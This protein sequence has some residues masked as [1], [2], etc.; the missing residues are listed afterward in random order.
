MASPRQPG[1]PEQRA[2]L[3]A[4]LVG[5][6]L[7]AGVAE[8]SL[9]PAAAAVGTSDRM[10]VYYFGSRDGLLRAVLAA[11][12]ERLQAGL[13]AGLP[14]ARLAPEELV[15]AAWRAL[16]DPAAEPVLAVYLEV[17]GLAARGREPYAAVAAE[18]AAA[19]MAWIAD[20]V[21]APAAQRADAAAG[22]LAVLDGLLLVRAVA[23]APIADQAAPWIVQALAGE[24]RP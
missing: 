23:G 4:G 1:R 11:V 21:D 3:L 8:L 16:Q 7:R 24:L 17:A 18:Q 15:A 10:L 6:V 12:G 5:H 20:R 19:W 14:P 22:V 9:R 2:A 13:A